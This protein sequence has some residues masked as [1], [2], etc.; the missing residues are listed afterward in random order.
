MLG[1]IDIL[2]PNS[3]LKTGRLK[4]FQAFEAK[5]KAWSGA[6]EAY[7]WTRKKQVKL[8]QKLLL[9]WWKQWQWQLQ[10]LLMRVHIS[11]TKNKSSEKKV[12]NTLN[13]MKKSSLSEK[14]HILFSNFVDRINKQFKNSMGERFEKMSWKVRCPSVFFFLL[15]LWVSFEQ[16][17]SKV[18]QKTKKLRS[19]QTR[20]K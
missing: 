12:Q 1:Q 5:L 19:F 17:A 8:W 7:S 16:P 4:G 3:S 18:F 2:L 9:T 20:K 10:Y 6:V 15:F 13:C 11:Q 14:S